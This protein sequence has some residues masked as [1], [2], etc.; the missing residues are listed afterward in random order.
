VQPRPGALAIMLLMQVTWVGRAVSDQL[1]GV[2]HEASSLVTY[3]AGRGVG[4][5]LRNGDGSADENET[6]GLH[7]DV[8]GERCVRVG[9]S[10]GR[11]CNKVEMLSSR[12]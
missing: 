4:R 12:R 3:T 7:C 6:E 8:R 2:S 10:V 11:R 1:N 9:G 5:D